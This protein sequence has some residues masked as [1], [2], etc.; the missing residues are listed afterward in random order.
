[1]GMANAE[2]GPDE[3]PSCPIPHAARSMDLELCRRDV[4]EPLA[5]LA[6]QL[7]GPTRA[8]RITVAVG[9]RVEPIEC[10]ASCKRVL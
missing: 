3:S 5:E 9:S 10:K 2:W 1:M 8:L 7:V 6:P 4:V